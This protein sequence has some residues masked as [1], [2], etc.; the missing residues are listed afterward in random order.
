MLQK[1]LFTRELAVLLRGGVPIREALQSL[2]EK[3]ETKTLKKM[4][5][6]LLS[7]VEN[8]QPL[9]LALKRL[10]KIFDSLYVNL[11]EIGETTGRLNDNLVFLSKEMDSAYAL[12]KKV[13][14]I[15][16]YP[17]I[18]L[19]CAFVLGAAISIFIL[20]KLIRLFDAFQVTLP[21]A[22][23]ILLAIAGFLNDYGFWF[24]GGIFVFMLL[25]RFVAAIPVLKPYWH[26]ALYVLPVAGGLTR[27]IGLA[28]FSRDMGI[29][30]GSGLPI[31][32]A[33]NIEAKV[34]RNRAFAKHIH[35]LAESVAEGRSLGEELSKNPSRLF[36]SMAP[37]MIAAGEKTGKL[38]ETFLY[39]EEFFTTEI[40]R[41]IKN[42]TVLLEPILLLIIGLIVAFLALAILTP[43]YSLTDAIR[44]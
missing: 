28:S 25:L 15:L 19:G 38:S 30:L 27:D 34:T 3:A 17:S 43:I 22:T 2:E 40:D 5:Q 24:F 37:K 36:P 33:L 20:P 41:K 23:R 31:L 7:Q 29:M 18:V 44:R 11:V 35:R 9:S 1:M 32:D 39:L 12:R 13:Q 4:I 21:L 26:R 14:A 6:A 8:G 42:A 10:P 16:L